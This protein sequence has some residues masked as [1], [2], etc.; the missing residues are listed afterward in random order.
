M[1]SLDAARDA[2]A[3]AALAYEE[4]LA[5]VEAVAGRAGDARNAAFVRVH[6]A[7]VAMAHAQAALQALSPPVAQDRSFETMIS[8]GLVGFDLQGEVLA[9]IYAYQHAGS[10]TASAPAAYDSRRP[11]PFQW[12]NNPSSTASDP[13][14][15]A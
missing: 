15:A 12:V 11:V 10:A 5:E 7:T 1:S 4:A 6:D 2:F 8:T 13:A 3:K 9:S 14:T